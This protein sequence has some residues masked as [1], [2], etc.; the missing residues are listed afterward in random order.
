MAGYTQSWQ[1]VIVGAED[2]YLACGSDAS[3]AIGGSSRSQDTWTRARGRAERRSECNEDSCAHG[4]EG[5]GLQNLCC[6]QVVLRRGIFTLR[7]DLLPWRTFLVVEVA[8][9]WP[10]HRKPHRAIDCRRLAVLEDWSASWWDITGVSTATT[11]VRPMPLHH[12]VQCSSPSP[13]SLLTVSSP[14]GY[15]G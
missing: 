9:Q 8:S 7:T 13:L 4:R 10:N 2:L 14:T 5:E 15:C 12:H 3:G 1:A 11:R 6:S